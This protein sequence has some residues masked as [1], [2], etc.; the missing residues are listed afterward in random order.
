M[1]DVDHFKSYND[2]YGHVAGD[3]CLKTIASTIRSWFRDNDLVARYGGEEFMIVVPGL[4]QTAMRVLA[5]KICEAVQAL[6]IPHC[7]SPHGVVT[8]SIGV[9]NAVPEVGKD[10]I[11]F[12]Q[13][14]DTALYRAKDRGRNTV[15]IYN[16]AGDLAIA[17]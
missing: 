15:A 11:Y 3:Q 17:S 4:S 6:Q 16:E 7:A 5:R 10:A 14:A 1:I 13:Q 9:V 8:V 12:L 2:R